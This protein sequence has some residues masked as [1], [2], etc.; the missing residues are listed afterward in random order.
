MVALRGFSE[1][2]AERE[3][4]MWVFDGEEWT[5]EGGSVGERKPADAHPMFGEMMPELQIIEIVHVPATPR[6]NYIPVP[7]P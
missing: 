7:L 5:E 6:T 4:T 2:A 1:R 3:F